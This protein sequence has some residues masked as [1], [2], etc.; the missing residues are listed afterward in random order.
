[1]TEIS[2]STIIIII[3]ENKGGISMTNQELFE[4]AVRAAENAYCKYSGFSVG[5]ALLCE[6]GE[7]YTGCNIENSSYPLGNCAE[8]T[9]IFKAVSEGRKAFTA[10]AIAGSSDGNFSAPCY[11][12]GACRQVMSEFCKGSFRIIL[13]DGAYTL[14]ELL[15]KRFKL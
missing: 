14:D 6:D 7:V 1:M 15:P 13:S 11:P 8:R 10:I 3:S 4:L 9:A 5:A 12:C 2:P